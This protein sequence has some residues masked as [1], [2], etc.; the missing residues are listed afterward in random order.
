MTAGTRAEGEVERE[1]RRVLRR[2]AGPGAK[3]AARGTEFFALMLPGRRGPKELLRVPADLVKAFRRRDWIEADA[4]EPACFRLSDAGLGWLKRAMASADPFAAQHQLRASRDMVE[5][6][7]VAHTVVVNEG[8]SPLGWLRRRRGSDGQ[9]LITRLQLEAGERLRTDFTIAQMTPR[10]AVDL[11]APVVAGRRGA[12][13][14]ALLPEIVLAA[15]QRVRRA[16]SDAGP[17][18]ADLLL[19]VCCHLKGLEAAER[20]N[21]CPRRSAKIVLQI[22]LDRLALHYGLLARAPARS[23]MRSWRAPEPDQRDAG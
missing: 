15:K 17:G 12:K 16:L 1:G 8:E 22:A 9:P 20:H 23:P 18:L 19:D 4:G 5:P 10:M 6:G 14:D 13:T 11:T 3:L 7:G 2:L 21:G